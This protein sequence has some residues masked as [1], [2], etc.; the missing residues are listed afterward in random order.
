MLM[1]FG[2]GMLGGG[3]RS[4]LRWRFWRHWV[5]LWVWMGLW[6]GSIK[7]IDEER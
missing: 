4:L 1:V 6:K 5:F 3:I 2:V 7:G